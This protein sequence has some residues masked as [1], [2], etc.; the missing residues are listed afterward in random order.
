MDIIKKYYEN[1]NICKNCKGI[2]EV[3]YGQRLSDVR[4]K[5]FCS[6]NCSASYNNKNRTNKERIICPQCGGKKHPDGKICKICYNNNRSINEKTLGY[7]IKGQKYLTSK[8]Q[9][10]RKHARDVIEKSD[11]EKVCSYCK[12][13]EFD[14]I[15]E[16]HHVKSI[17]EFDLNTKIK[18]INDISNLI[19][20]CPNHHSM[21][22]K[23]L[24]RV[25]I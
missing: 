2:I 19:W 23:G 16:V 25:I 17:L 1:P 5:K 9:H 18:V 3:K 8:C 10:I 12:N 20:L 4:R 14:E 24:I 21:C 13:H 7:Y 15:L 6:H 22:E 11:K